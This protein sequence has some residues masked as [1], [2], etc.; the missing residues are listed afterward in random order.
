MTDE[1]FKL[2]HYVG[3]EPELFDLLE[4][5]EETRSIHDQ[6]RHRERL[7]SLQASLR[8]IVNPEAAD[9]QA[10]DDQNAFIERFGGREK[11][12][13]MTRFGATPVPQDTGNGAR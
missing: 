6:P 11:A 1:R 5:P 7:D 10:K 3:Y 8:A 2:H 4:D 12:L 13:T 9:R